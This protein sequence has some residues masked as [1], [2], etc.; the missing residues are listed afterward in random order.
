MV[1]NICYIVKE[2]HWISL[3]WFF[4][5][6][7][8]LIWVQQVSFSGVIQFILLQ[9]FLNALGCNCLLFP[10]SPSGGWVQY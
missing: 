6:K 4:L 2:Y 10:Y 5:S 3:T 8:M 9:E 7:A 1:Q